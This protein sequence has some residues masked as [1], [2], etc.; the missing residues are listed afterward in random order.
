MYIHAYIHTYMSLTNYYLTRFN[1]QLFFKKKKLITSLTIKSYMHKQQKERVISPQVE[2]IFNN[3]IPDDVDV[4]TDHTKLI[5]HHSYYREDLFYREN[6]ISGKFTKLFLFKLI[7][8]SKNYKIRDKLQFNGIFFNKKY[9]DNHINLIKYFK[10]NINKYINFRNTKQ[11]LNLIKELYY[12]PTTISNKIKKIKKHPTNQIAKFIKIKNILNILNINFIKKKFNLSKSKVSSINIKK[13]LT[14]FTYI[15]KKQ[16]DYVL[17]INNKNK[18]RNNYL[19]KK[20]TSNLNT[21]NI[22][23]QYSINKIHILKLVTSYNLYTKFTSKINTRMFYKKKIN[24]I[25][26]IKNKRKFINELKFKILNNWNL[27][28]NNISYKP[29]IYRNMKKMS[30]YLMRSNNKYNSN[31]YNS[32]KYKC[33]NKIKT[34]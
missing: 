13:K 34:D 5:P 22:I 10:L 33:L 6:L 21:Y 7:K 2:K 11:V 30:K 19:K 31:K 18:F 28:I 3:T 8:V 15:K 14:I 29:K 27:I 12:Y 25:K 32:N 9:I 16:P 23:K 17:K 4:Q 24:L 20:T 26:K 1:N